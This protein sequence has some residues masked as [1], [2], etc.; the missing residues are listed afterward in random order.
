MRVDLNYQIYSI[1]TR[2]YEK[3]CTVYSEYPHSYCT[4]QHNI[5]TYTTPKQP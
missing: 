2:M 3:M 5:R 4:T 1:H